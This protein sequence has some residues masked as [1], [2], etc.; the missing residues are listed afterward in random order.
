[1]V[2]SWFDMAAE[3]LDERA[4][5][6]RNGTT[7]RARTGQYAII[8]PTTHCASERA[9]AGTKSGALD[10][11]DARLHYW[12]TY[13]AWFDRW[14]RDKEHAID[15]LP[16]IQYYEIGRSAWRSSDRWPVAGMR[17]VPFYLRSGGGANSA[18][19]NG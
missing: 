8:S 15:S 9:V 16:R 7:P 6:E 13:L 1:H 3:A 18:R 14:L 2:S 10:V 5:F 17:E 19:G 11:G 12:D 4:I